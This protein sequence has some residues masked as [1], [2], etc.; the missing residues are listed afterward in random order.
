MW[1]SKKKARTGAAEIDG[2]GPDMK[3][4]IKG[5]CRDLEIAI[6]P[7][8]GPDARIVITGARGGQARIRSEEYT[9]LATA[10]QMITGGGG[11]FLS[12]GL[13]LAE[14]GKPLPELT[15]DPAAG[16]EERIV[17][18]DVHGGRAVTSE[19]L[20]AEVAGDWSGSGSEFVI[21]A[22]GVDSRMSP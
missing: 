19:R 20:L 21:L 15:I 7:Q 17:I 10:A 9:G 3:I 6:D 22:M 4:K 16:P 12:D 13:A 1:G 18:R 11:G 14:D 5:S 2:G 8:A